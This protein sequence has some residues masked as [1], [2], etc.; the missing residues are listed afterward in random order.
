M[1]M[2]YNGALYIRVIRKQGHEMAEAIIYQH[3]I[4]VRCSASM[5]LSYWCTDI[6]A[7]SD[8]TKSTLC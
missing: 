6:L 5:Y 3:A 4:S 2:G 1:M 8:Q 7:L